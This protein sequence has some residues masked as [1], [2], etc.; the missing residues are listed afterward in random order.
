MIKYVLKEGF[1]FLDL[2]EFSGL[3]LLVSYLALLL[4]HK[5]VEL[6]QVLFDLTLTRL[7]LA[8]PALQ[9]YVWTP[10]NKLGRLR[11]T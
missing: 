5:V 7:N 6:H 2:I 4:T 10:F 8:P 1:L 3:L 9:R 11:Y